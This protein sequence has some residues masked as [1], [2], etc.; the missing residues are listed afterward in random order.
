MALLLAL[1]ASR[2]SVAQP[3]P[4]FAQV[5]A[6]PEAVATDAELSQPLDYV[7]RSDG[8]LVFVEFQSRQVTRLSPDGTVR[9]RV[10]REG[11]GPGEFRTPDRLAVLPDEGV[12]VFDLGT[13]RFSQLDS[14]G[15]F[16][17]TLRA[18]MQ[19]IVHSLLESPSGEVLVSG[20]SA[21]PRGRSSAL[22]VFSS[23]LRYRRSAGDLP[24]SRDP[25]VRRFVGTGSIRPLASGGFVHTRDFPYEMVRYSWAFQPIARTKVPAVVDPPERWRERTVSGGRASMRS[26]PAARRPS[27]ITPLSDN[28]LLGGTF[29]LED[30]LVLFDAAGRRLDDIRRPDPWSTSAA[31]D[32]ARRQLLI[33]GERDDVPTL[34]QV[35]L[36]LR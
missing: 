33:C 19:L 18:D 36:R 11:S 10:G 6:P 16:V 31:Y 15:A 4:T 29:S 7:A 28:L 22:H 17:R 30:R 13:Q 21:D 5:L 9:W 3:G 24:E 12:L 32:R 2:S 20:W 8:S 14:S 1:L 34:Y 23:D 25:E 35:R 26:N 27:A